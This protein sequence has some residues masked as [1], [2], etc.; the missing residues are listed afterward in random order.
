MTPWG[1][2][3]IVTILWVATMDALAADATPQ[4]DVHPGTT[5]VSPLA[6]QQSLDQLSATRDRPLFSPTR[7]PPAPPPIVVPVAPPP[8]PPPDVAL[9]GVVMDGDDARAVVRV[10]QEAK[11]IRVQIGDDIGG[12]KVGQIEARYLVLLLNGRTAKFGM[13]NGKSTRRFPPAGSI[14]QSQVS[15]RPNLVQSPTSTNGSASPNSQHPPVRRHQ[16]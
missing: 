8:A 14:A 5:P 11:T 1:P 4:R 6:A 2:L 13:F 10:G 16:R 9:L 3:L 12:W 7:R 15:Q